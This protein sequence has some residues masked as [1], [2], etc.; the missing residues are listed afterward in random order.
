MNNIKKIKPIKTKAD[1]K[2]NTP[3]LL[4]EILSNN[5][6]AILRIPLQIF[7]NL[8]IDVAKRASELNDKKLNSLMARLALY[9]ITDPYSPV[10]DKKKTD[11][12]INYESTPIIIKPKK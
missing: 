4:K 6:T 2:V 11:E 9:E 5:E 3:N 7:G 8:L 12:I 10:Y 1:W